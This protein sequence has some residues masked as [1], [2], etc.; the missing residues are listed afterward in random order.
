MGG[1]YVVEGENRRGIMW[2]WYEAKKKVDV[3]VDWRGQRGMN[4]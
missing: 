3:V 2:W 4:S 1:T